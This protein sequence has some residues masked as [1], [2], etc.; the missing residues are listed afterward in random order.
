M[1]SAAAAAASG[2]SNEQKQCV[3]SGG[4]GDVT[5][6]APR[7][8]NVSFRDNRSSSCPPQRRWHVR[9]ASV[10]LLYLKVLS[11]SSMDAY[12]FAKFLAMW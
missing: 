12:V 4:A 6:I 5:L 11:S 3:K 10:G 8:I 9:C 7:A 2:E 1:S